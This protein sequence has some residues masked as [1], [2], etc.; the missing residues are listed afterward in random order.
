VT[1]HP[2]AAP[3]DAEPVPELPAGAALV[4]LVP[5]IGDLDLAAAAAWEFA[6]RVAN[7]GR[8]VALI[9]CYVD[10]PRLHAVAGE[11]NEDG[12][13]DVFDYGASLSRIARAQPEGSLFFVPAGTFSPDPAGMMARPRWRRLSAGFRHEDA[14]MLLFLPPDCIGALASEVDGLVALAPGQPDA[15]LAG[16]PEIQA[17]LR[18][19]TPLLATFSGSAGMAPPPAPPPAPSQRREQPAPPQPPD[20]PA[21]SV[22]AQPPSRADAPSAAVEPSSAVIAKPAA[23]PRR[24]P[25]PDLDLPLDWTEPKVEAPRRFRAVYGLLLVLAA[26]VAVFAYRRQLGWGG[27]GD[28]PPPEPVARLAPAYRSLAPHPVDTLPFAVQVAAWTSF[29]Q[30]LEDADTIEGRGFHPMVAPV[31]IQRTLWYRIYVGPVASR[32]EADSL[33]RAVRS[34]GLDGSRAAAVALVPL[35][36]ALR[37]AASLL[38]ARAERDRLRSAGLAAFVLGQGDGAYRV[39]TGAFD[40]PDQAVYLDSLLTSTG[41]AGPLGPRVGFR[42]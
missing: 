21:A 28:A 26:A 11:S 18:R 12:I 4:A 13:V 20:E 31:R 27:P 9:D 7:A 29:P 41:S 32:R 38:A 37:R 10:E 24:Q 2:P 23:P 17:A 35:S 42:P 40:Q 6:R 33:L 16:S 5:A 19:G 34:A 39:F 22:A 14:V 30:A 3:P 25:D 8:R 15:D 36:F 1:L